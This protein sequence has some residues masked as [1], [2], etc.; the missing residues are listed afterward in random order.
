M[1]IR[2]IRNTELASLLEL[3]TQ[4][5]ESDS[6]RPPATIIEATWNEIQH[7]KNIRYFGVFIDGALVSTCTIAVIPNL[8]R[9]CRPYGLI[10]NVVTASTH[11]KQGLGKLVLQAALD[12]AWQ[13]D[14]YKVM[15]MTARLDEPTLRF[16]ES[17]GFSRNDKQAFIAR[18]PV[19]Q[20][21]KNK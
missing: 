15:L 12:F 8:T 16:Y 19:Q 17:A 14:C 10:E 11:R 1:Q 21:H 7:N 13:R 4:L 18:H 5:H 9:S 2:E 6:P 3:Y 20:N